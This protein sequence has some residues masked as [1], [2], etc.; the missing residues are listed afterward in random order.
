MAENDV[1]PRRD[2]VSGMAGGSPLGLGAAPNGDSPEL[3]PNF[4]FLLNTGLEM[5]TSGAGG[6]NTSGLFRGN[7][8]YRGSLPLSG[9]IRIPLYSI[10]FFLAVVGNILVIV[11]LA[12]NKRM[13]T[14]TNVFLLNLSVSDLL[15]AV[16]CMPFTLIPTLLQ[17]F[18]F[19]KVMCVLIRYVQGKFSFTRIISNNI[20]NLSSRSH[21]IYRS[22]QYRK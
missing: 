7:R 3:L 16:F 11:T 13:R 6:D 15:L 18:I 9:E 12:Q 5:S 10:I 1:I 4:T 21:S 22:L 17:D 2:T 20:I 19:G 8:T 14:V